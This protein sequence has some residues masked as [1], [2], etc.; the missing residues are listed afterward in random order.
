MDGETGQMQPPARSG[1]N[2]L[3]NAREPEWGMGGYNST[4]LFR[5]WTLSLPYY[6]TNAM[7]KPKVHR[8][9]SS[10]PTQVTDFSVLPTMGGFYRG[11]VGG[12]Y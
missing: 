3:R 6:D 5:L 8:L 9:S 11:K 7:S 2:R 4:L 12:R 1:D 10:K